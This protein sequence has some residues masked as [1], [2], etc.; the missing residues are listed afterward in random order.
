MNVM[1]EF[2]GLVYGVY[3]AKTGGGFTPGG[4]SLHNT[5]L[6]HGPDRAAFE[7]ASN[8]KLEPAQAGRH[9]G[10]HVRDPLSAARHPLR[11]RVAGTAGELRRLR[12]KPRQT[13]RP[14]SPMTDLDETH[15]A[16]RRS[17]VSGANGHP[18][19]PVQNLPLGVFSPEHGEGAARRRDRR[20]YPRPARARCQRPALRRRSRGGAGAGPDAEC[21]GGSWRRPEA[22]ALRKELSRL[23]A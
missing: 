23:L 2:M 6:P 10:L 5:M 13:F 14:E 1:S 15:D 12:A 16:S 4:I 7:A 17:W 3:D 9:A 21:V 22:R 18:A 19:F 20:P 8:A 11:R